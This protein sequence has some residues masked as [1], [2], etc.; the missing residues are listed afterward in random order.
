MEKPKIT[1]KS[2]PDLRYYRYA[3]DKDKIGEFYEIYNTVEE[4]AERLNLYKKDI[5][6]SARNASKLYCKI[7]NCYYYWSNGTDFRHK[8]AN[9]Y[10][11]IAKYENGKPVYDTNK[12]LEIPDNMNILV[13]EGGWIKTITNK[14]TPGNINNGEY[15]YD[16]I[17]DNKRKT[18]LVKEIVVWVFKGLN[19]Y[20]ERKNNNKEDNRLINLVASPEPS[21]PIKNAS[22][23]IVVDEKELIGLYNSIAEASKKL[24][25]NRVSIYKHITDQT[26]YLGYF[27]ISERYNKEQFNIL[28]IYQQLYLISIYYKFLIKMSHTTKNENIGKRSVQDN[29]LQF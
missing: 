1:S 29:Y 11:R 5:K 21:H 15:Y 17:I 14:L 2:K 13:S 6:N 16:I 22:R 19:C 8:S 12:W 9:E 20:V 25:A 24:K 27:W 23:I 10:T 28:L 18:L 4:A 3:D 26:K 7:R